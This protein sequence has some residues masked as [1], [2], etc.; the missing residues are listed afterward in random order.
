LL[1]DARMSLKDV[2]PRNMT[3]AE[4]GK[5]KLART[6]EGHGNS[7]GSLNGGGR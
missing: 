3:K 2:K 4:K 7:N 6:A 1:S 5:R